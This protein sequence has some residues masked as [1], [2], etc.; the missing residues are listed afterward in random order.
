VCGVSL[1]NECADQSSDRGWDREI[2]YSLFD[3][4]LRLLEVLPLMTINGG[5][6]IS[7]IRL[8]DFPELRPRIADAMF[9]EAVRVG[10]GKPWDSGYETKDQPNRAD[11]LADQK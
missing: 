10:V 4:H 9:S 6:R 3:A 1:A 2:Y 5:L 8:S 7:G 11:R